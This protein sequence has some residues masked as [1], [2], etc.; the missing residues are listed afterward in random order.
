MKKSPWYRAAG[1]VKY[2]NYVIKLPFAFLSSH[3]LIVYE[4]KHTYAVIFTNPYYYSALLINAVMAYILISVVFRITS[5]LDYYYPWG[6]SYKIRMPRQL[7]G[8]VLFPILPAIILATLYFAYYEINILNTVYFSRYLQ[9]IVFMLIILNA[10]LFYHWHILSKQKSIPKAL[11]EN[12]VN[13]PIAKETFTQIA[14]VFIED[15]NCFA[16]NLQ[17]EKIIWNDTL[18]KSINYLPRSQ[19]YMIKR[20]FIVNRAVINKVNVVNSRKTT[21]KLKSPLN[22]EVDVSQREN[23]DFKKWMLRSFS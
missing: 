10:Y 12:Y 5:L 19:F 14:C 7:L 22:L 18:I 6:R 20:S 21:I 13:E 16:Y 1:A 3:L 17:G 8:G 4:E 23:A 9:Q 15:K 11:L 2:P